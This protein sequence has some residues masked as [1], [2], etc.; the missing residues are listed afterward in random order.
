VARAGCP[1]KETCLP[2]I[3]T[4][5]GVH[6]ASYPVATGVLD[7]EYIGRG[8]DVH[9]SSPSSAEIKNEWSY[10]ST[11]PIWFLGVDLCALHVIFDM[12]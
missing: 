12:K 5:V 4:A 3:Q 7:R 9:N 10:T 6:L 2:N 1:G 11:P 8:H